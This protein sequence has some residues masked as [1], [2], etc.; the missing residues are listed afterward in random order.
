MVPTSKE[1]VPPA[2]IL[3]DPPDIDMGWDLPCLTYDTL[4]SVGGPL[5]G[6]EVP[7]HVAMCHHCNMVVTPEPNGWLFSHHE[8]MYGPQL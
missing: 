2:L 4:P 1:A 6:L 3:G 5:G 7:S 8:L